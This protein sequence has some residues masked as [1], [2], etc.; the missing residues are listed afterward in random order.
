MW[1]YSDDEQS[2][3][4]DLISNVLHCLWGNCLG[5]CDWVMH[6]PWYLI[7]QYFS[8]AISL[9]EN[10]PHFYTR[11]RSKT[12][13]RKMLLGNRQNPI[14]QDSFFFLVEKFRSKNAVF[15]FRSRVRSGLRAVYLKN[16]TQKSKQA[17]PD[18]G[19]ALTPLYPPRGSS[20]VMH[21]WRPLALL[22]RRSP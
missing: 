14:A 19:P 5:F 6:T 8:I 18:S 22:T 21:C 12:L 7:A 17:I 3:P 10:H 1:P 2:S 4:H 11:S 15:R 9:I 13:D 16:K 20:P